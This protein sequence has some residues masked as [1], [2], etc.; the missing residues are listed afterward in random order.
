MIHEPLPV[1]R[2]ASSP[3]ADAQGLAIIGL[4]ILL[5][6]G[7]ALLPL[8]SG[9][10]AFPLPAETSTLAP[11]PSAPLPILVNINAA[12]AEALQALPG[13]GPTLAARIVAEREAHGPYQSPE[14]LERVPGI[15]PKRLERIRPLV[16]MAEE[17]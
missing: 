17:R 12:G 4:A 6:A 10:P 7:T 13:I 11:A 2:D 16:R 1:G 14:D 15:G 5:A 8:G 9:G 3:S